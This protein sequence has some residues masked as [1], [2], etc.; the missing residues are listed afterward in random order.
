M[1]FAAFPKNAKAAQI[2]GEDRL[3]AR[4]RKDRCKSKPK[5][6]DPCSK[7]LLVTGKSRKV[8]AEEARE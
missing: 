5:A 4:C 3:V 8:G 6:W 7:G 2:R 1:S